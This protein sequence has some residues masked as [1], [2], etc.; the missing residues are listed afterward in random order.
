MGNGGCAT[1]EGGEVL[2]SY[3][4][5]PASMLVW[6]VRIQSVIEFWAAATICSTSLK[7]QCEFYDAAF[8]TSS[9]LSSVPGAHPARKMDLRF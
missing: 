2:N 9:S 7:S 5:N 4:V 3:E 6:P 1:A 8:F